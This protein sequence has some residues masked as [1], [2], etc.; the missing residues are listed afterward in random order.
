MNTPMKHRVLSLLLAVCFVW[1][2]TAC[3]K[4]P[5]KNEASSNAISGYN[6]TSEGI[7]EFFVNGA[8]GSGIS[9]GGGGATVCCVNLPDKWTPDLKVTIEWKRSDCGERGPGGGDRCPS[10]SHLQ[11]GDKIPEWQMKTL[12]KEVPIEPYEKSDT[13][14]V[15]FLPNDEVKVYVYPDDPHAVGHPAKLGSPHPLDNPNWKDSK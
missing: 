13:V 3:S 14:Q 9:I 15:F 1:M 7:Q 12:K 2:L 8:W 5:P 11:P 6:Y 10:F 4:E